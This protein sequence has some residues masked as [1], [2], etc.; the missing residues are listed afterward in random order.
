VSRAENDRLPGNIAGNRLAIEQVDAW[1]EPLR[2]EVHE[3]HFLVRS[4]GP[5]GDFETGDDIVRK[6]QVGKSEIQKIY[7][8]SA[9][10]SSD[11][12]FDER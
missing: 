1:N 7:P 3:D 11:A 4:A 10:S 12:E 8:S 9:D 5:D 6:V 2:Y